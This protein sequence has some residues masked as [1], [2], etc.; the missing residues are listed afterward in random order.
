M[1]SRQESLQSVLD[2]AAADPGFLAELA[3]QPLE[4]VLAA[5]VQVSTAELKQLLSL[6]GATDAELLEVLRVR[7]A[8]TAVDDSAGC[9]GR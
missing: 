7:V 8:H 5:G 3:A 6:A 1:T 9:G 4:T 2:R